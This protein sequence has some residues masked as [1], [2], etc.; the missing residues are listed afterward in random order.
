M[1]LGIW[2]GSPGCWCT[3]GHPRRCERARWLWW[4]EPVAESPAWPE[5]RPETGS[6]TGV[7]C[8]S[9]PGSRQTGKPWRN[10]A[11]D[12]PSRCLSVSPTLSVCASLIRSFSHLPHH[13]FSLQIIATALMKYVCIFS[14][15]QP[16][17]RIQGC[18]L[19]LQR[20]REREREREI[21][22]VFASGDGKEREK[23]AS[24]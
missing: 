4:A 8:F 19:T 24:F 16:E 11:A 3:C 23:T 9:L 5:E 17:G 18:V 6:E 20:E 7:T 14:L 22:E 10:D 2:W 13:I 12:A 21:C 1:S 15:V